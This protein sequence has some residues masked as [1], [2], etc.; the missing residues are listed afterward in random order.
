MSKDTYN[1]HRTYE[2]K[3]D[4]DTFV[5]DYKKALI[6]APILVVCA[7]IFY[8]ALWAITAQ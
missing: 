7:W 1:T 4:K 6:I 8:V 2:R 5:S 3:I